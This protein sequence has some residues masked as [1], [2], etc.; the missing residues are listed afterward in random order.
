MNIHNKIC[1]L[2]EAADAPGSLAK[3][4]WELRIKQAGGWVDYK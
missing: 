3:V 2:A 4:G 1:S